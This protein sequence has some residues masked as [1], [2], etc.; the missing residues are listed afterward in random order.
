[1]NNWDAG[2]YAPVGADRVVRPYK[3]Q[4]KNKNG[5]GK[6]LPYVT[7]KRGTAQNAQPFPSSV[8]FADSF[9]PGGSWGAADSFSC[10]GGFF[11]L[12]GELSVFGQLFLVLGVWV[13]G[14]EGLRIKIRIWSASGGSFGRWRLGG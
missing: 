10:G 6:P 14:G 11:A 2:R 1:M 4:C 13:K 7:T 5:R 12:F 9:P 8:G 3:V